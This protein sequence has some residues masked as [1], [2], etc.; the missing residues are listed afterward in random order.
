[1]NSIFMCIDTH[2][3]RTGSAWRCFMGDSKPMRWIAVHRLRRSNAS[4]FDFWTRC[5]NVPT[6]AYGTRANLTEEIGP[7][8]TS[9]SINSNNDRKIM[10]TKSDY[11]FRRILT[12]KC[13]MRTP[14]ASHIKRETTRRDNSKFLFWSPS[15]RQVFIAGESFLLMRPTTIARS[16]PPHIW[17]S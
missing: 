16:V 9:T 2:S 5:R 17:P 15:Q 8:H 7:K 14:D 12:E 1:M 6:L 10:T 4:V 11:C 3:K 13:P